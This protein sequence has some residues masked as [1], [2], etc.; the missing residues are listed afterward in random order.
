MTQPVETKGL[1]GP[2]LGNTNAITHGLRAQRDGLVMPRMAR[3]LRYI[4]GYVF[5][6]RKAVEAQV[7]KTQ[8]KLDLATRS[9]ANLIAHY[10]RA[11]LAIYADLAERGEEMEPETRANLYTKALWAAERRHRLILSLVGDSGGE[12]DAWAEF[13]AQRAT[14][15]AGAEKGGLTQVLAETASDTL[16]GP[17][18]GELL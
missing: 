1:G 10:E 8:G 4:Q 12:D 11:S 6:L 7:E 18:K 2:P 9:A 17:R 16:T 14:E 3:K 13:D 5:K 15:A